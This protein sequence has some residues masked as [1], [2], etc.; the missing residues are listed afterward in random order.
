MID[1]LLLS[2]LILQLH[3][4]HTPLIL[5]AQILHREIEKKISVEIVLMPIT[6]QRGKSALI[7][8]LFSRLGDSAVH[9]K[10]LTLQLVKASFFGQPS[11]E[12]KTINS[13]GNFR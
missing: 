3:D 13:L 6:V 12:E 1:Q 10:A 7:L 9:I 5:T 2:P 11:S 4:S 8:G